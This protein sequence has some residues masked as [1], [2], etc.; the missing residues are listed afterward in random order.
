VPSLPGCVTQGET[1][2]EALDMARDAIAPYISVLRDRGEEVPV[3]AVPPVVAGVE[4]LVREEV[5]A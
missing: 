3:E 5:P 2:E 4:V 1:V